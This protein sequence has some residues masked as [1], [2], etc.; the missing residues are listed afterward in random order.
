MNKPRLLL[1]GAGSIGHEL[2][3]RLLFDFSI[4]CLDMDPLRVEAAAA[5][6]LKDV[7]CR[8][9]DATSRMV[10][11]QAGASQADTVVIAIA[12]EKTTLEVARVLRQGFGGVKIISLGITPQGISVL[13]SMQVQVVN[14]FTSGAFGIINTLK[15]HARTAY[16]IGLEQTEIREVTVRS[17][18]RLAHRP[19]E[20]IKPVNWNAGIIYRDGAI[21]V[22][23]GQT[24]LKPGDRVVILGEPSVLDTVS[25]ALT[26][27]GNRFPLE[28]GDTVLCVIN[29][30]ED[31][32]YF[33][34][35]R[36]IC[37]SFQPAEAVFA[38]SSSLTV[39]DRQRMA[40][41]L[42][43]FNDCRTS[44]TQISLD[45]MPDML[46][47]LQKEFCLI[48]MANRSFFAAAGRRAKGLLKQLPGKFGCPLLLTAG[49]FP[50]KQIGIVCAGCPDPV[51]AAE[52]A[53]ELSFVLDSRLTALLVSPSKYFYTDE[54]AEQF[55]RARQT[56]SD[57]SSVYKQRI[58]IMELSGNPVR[59][60]GKIIHGFDLSVM[61]VSGL[62]TLN[63]VAGFF[64][65]DVAWQILKQ[66]SVTVM[67][68]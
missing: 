61:E 29:G 25:A 47:D 30:D 2:M 5:P 9:G 50:Y 13:E 8:Q 60:V 44:E 38:F 48:T 20:S 37:S 31:E 41:F 26:F 10:L 32:H 28:Y 16:G 65:P 27:R 42:E 34:E 6:G 21:V 33:Q 4:T 12:R 52:N 53:L 24:H 11:E 57:V 55:Q 66:T 43:G 19:L 14:I 54:E 3:K 23:K 15:Q 39:S 59:A 51:R 56:V 17:G 58:S 35:L 18:S 36:Y 63:P 68:V 45:R 62:K 40:G 67:L 22:P 49:S 1:I 64:S 46:S 7:T